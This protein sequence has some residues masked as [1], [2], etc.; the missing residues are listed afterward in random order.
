MSIISKTVF[1]INSRKKHIKECQKKSKIGKKKL[2]KKPVQNDGGYYIVTTYLT[3]DDVL[4]VRFEQGT[5]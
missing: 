5:C 2:R 1:I 4:I 3:I